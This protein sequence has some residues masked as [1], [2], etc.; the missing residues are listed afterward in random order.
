MGDCH[1]DTY[2]CTRY[3]GA[4]EL[5]DLP[6]SSDGSLAMNCNIVALVAITRNYISKIALVAI[7]FIA[8]A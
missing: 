8:C 6:G 2:T 3:G 4:Y 5:Q 1:G 7:S